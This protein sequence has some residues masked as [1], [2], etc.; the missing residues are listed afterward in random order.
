MRCHRSLQRIRPLRCHGEPD[1]NS[2]L[3]AMH[4]PR[5]ANH[6][7]D[8]TKKGLPKKR[9]AQATN[10]ATPITAKPPDGC[11]TAR[12]AISAPTKYPAT[13]NSATMR[14]QRHGVVVVAGALMRQYLCQFQK[15]C[16]IANHAGKVIQVFSVRHGLPGL[17]TRTKTN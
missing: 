14:I 6:R 9:K 15:G 2:A 7:C 16:P 8:R 12:P 5:I 1:K 13:S 11:R 17:H 10:A 4:Q 3:T